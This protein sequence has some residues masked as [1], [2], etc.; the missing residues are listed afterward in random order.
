[1]GTN[2]ERPP[3]SFDPRTWEA[4]PR[5]DANNPPAKDRPR[6]VLHKAGIADAQG[7]QRCVRCGC[8]LPAVSPMHAPGTVVVIGE[9]KSFDS[10]MCAPPMP[11][12]AN[13]RTPPK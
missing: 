1:M 11:G 7:L 5:Y 4:I 3:G 10:I 9:G 2:D 12:P 8:H 13:V 6:P